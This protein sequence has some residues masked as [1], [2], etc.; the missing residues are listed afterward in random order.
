MYEGDNIYGYYREEAGKVYSYDGGSQQEKLE[1]DFTLGSGDVFSTKVYEV[2]A[3][4]DVEDTGSIKVNGKEYKT[5]T[6]QFR[7]PGNS[8]T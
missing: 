6:L 2:D 7:P 8:T 3:K 4:L 1:Y 5:Q